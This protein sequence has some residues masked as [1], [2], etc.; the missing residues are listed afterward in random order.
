MR[1]KAGIKS[2]IF[3]YAIFALFLVGA[4]LG[5][6]VYITHI[7]TIVRPDGQPSPGSWP[8][9]YA[10][11]FDHITIE[12][13][14]PMVSDDGQ[15]SLTRND[16]WMQILDENGMEIIAYNKPADIPNEYTLS[17]LLNIA[18]DNRFSGYTVFP[19]TSSEDSFEYIIGFPIGVSKVTMYFN[20]DR[21]EG[22][23]PIVFAVLS[24]VCLFVLLASMVYVAWLTKHLSRIVKSSDEIAARDYAPKNVTGVFGDAYKSLNRLDSE[25]RL[26]DAARADTD[27]MREEW[28][29]NITHDLKTPLSPIKGYAELLT[30]GQYA[31]STDEIKKY[32]QSILKNA[33]YTEQLI[34]DLKLAY[35]IDSG[36]IPVDIKIVNLSRETKEI[37]IDLLNNPDYSDRTIQYQCE[38]SNISAHIDMSLFR[39][40]L[41][42]IIINAL[43]HNSPETEVTVAVKTDDDIAIIVSDNGSGLTEDE[44]KKLF[45]RYYRGANTEEKPEGSGL[46][47]AIAKQIVEL[48]GGRI[49][50][51]SEIHKGTEI[52]LYL[53][54]GTEQN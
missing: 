25:I 12:N 22:G 17:E 43:V 14:M 45:S 16:L 9:Q 39:R 8:Q 10:E 5:L 33:T 1:N 20:R 15:A 35:H 13:G 38:K 42:N 26:S 40:A 21:Y 24:G 50:V 41:S 29:V 49:E 27:R 2:V 36:T 44:V 48:H 18:T 3:L 4:V 34:N 6:A 54:K 52:I 32:G 23:R 30:D 46:G 37:V 53:P 47:L 11:S 7:S 28:I 19:V 31:V 51:Q